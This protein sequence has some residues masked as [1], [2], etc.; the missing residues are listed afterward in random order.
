MWIYNNVR[1]KWDAIVRRPMKLLDMFCGYHARQ[2]LTV[3]ALARM[4]VT[5]AAL[6]V[7]VRVL[8]FFPSSMWAVCLPGSLERL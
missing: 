2:A 7:E 4:G 5:L 3:E 8:S 6:P 1:A